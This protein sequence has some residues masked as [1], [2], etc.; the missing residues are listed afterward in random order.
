MLESTQ[1]RAPGDPSGGSFATGRGSSAVT[2]DPPATDRG[3]P[4]AGLIAA[5]PDARVQGD[6]GVLVADVTYRSAEARPGSLFFCVPGTRV[7]GHDFADR[8]VAAGASVLVVERPLEVQC[9]QVVV[10]SVR[11]VMGPIS[12]AFFGH[13]AD[14]L[15]M[16]GV[17]GTN[18]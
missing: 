11:R 8:A 4:L 18:G 2:I 10:P 7:D 1:L 5:T 16:V 14:R 12:A 9:V 13:P 15:T 3:T 6:A 17:T